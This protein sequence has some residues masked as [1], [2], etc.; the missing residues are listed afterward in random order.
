MRPPPGGEPYFATTSGGAMMLLLPNTSVLS[1]EGILSSST[2]TYSGSLGTSPNRGFFTSSHFGSVVR[3]ATLGSAWAGK[4]ANSRILT[5][6]VERSAT[7][8][9]TGATRA[10]HRRQLKGTT[11]RMTSQAYQIPRAPPAWSARARVRPEWSGSILGHGLPREPLLRRVLGPGQREPPG[12]ERAACDPGHPGH[13]EIRYAAAL[14]EHGH[15][16]SRDLERLGHCD[17]PVRPHEQ[18]LGLRLLGHHQLLHRRR[19]RTLEALR[20]YQGMG[21]HEGHATQIGRALGEIGGGY[22]ADPD[23][24][25]GDADAVFG[26]SARLAR[27]RHVGRFRE[28]W[29]HALDLRIAEHLLVA[30]HDLARVGMSE[31]RALAEDRELLPDLGSLLLGEINVDLVALHR[32]HEPLDRGKRRHDVIEHEAEGGA[33]LVGDVRRHRRRARHERHQRPQERGCPAK[34]AATADDRDLPRR[35]PRR[36]RSVGRHRRPGATCHR[37]RPAWP[38]RAPRPG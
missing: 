26:L 3:S 12:E 21:D 36:Q 15:E 8:Q 33:D 20:P 18:F 19:I 37:S 32:D 2:Q 25:T 1:E 7:A 27:R 14:E 28:L 17:R 13:V 35:E 11:R 16:P 29:Q 31:H 24:P 38:A 34:G 4:P 6:P 23:S 22:H 30:S 5:Q 10:G 9:R